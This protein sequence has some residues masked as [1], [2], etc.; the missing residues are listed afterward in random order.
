MKFATFYRNVNLGQSRSPTRLQLEGALAEAGAIE[1]HSF[2]TNG[3]AV[4]T[5]ASLAAAREIVARAGSVMALTCGLREPAF[6]IELEPLAALVAEQPFAGIEAERLNEFNASFMN[7]AQLARL[8]APLVSPRGDVEVIRVTA[9]VALSV[10]R[11]VGAGMGSPTPFFE[12]LLG[13]PVTTR[14]WGTIERL[15]RKHG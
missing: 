14:G 4:F 5:A 15:A 7:D 2:Q 3:T 6:T 9:F 1:P 13:A 8:S 11:R 12:K 10:S